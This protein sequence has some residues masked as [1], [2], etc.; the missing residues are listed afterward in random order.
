MA[1]VQITV[2]FLLASLSAFA[3]RYEKVPFGDFEQWV[4]RYIDESQIIGGNWPDGHHRR[5]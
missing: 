2:L 4:V 5:Q 1:K 3:Q